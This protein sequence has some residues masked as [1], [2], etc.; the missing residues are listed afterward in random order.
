MKIDRSQITSRGMVPNGIYTVLI[1]EVNN[2]PAASGTEQTKISLE[3]LAPA[4]VPFG[5]TNYEVAGVPCE[6]RTWWSEK[7]VAKSIEMCRDLGVPGVDDAEDSAQLQEAL[8][9][10]EGH[11][12]LAVLEGRERVKRETPLPNQ[13]P[14]EAPEMKDPET[15]ERITD[16]WEITNVTFR[17]GTLRNADGQFPY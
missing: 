14:W 10:L 11:T 13:K 9:K 5:G 16:G 8:K 17:P 2:N 7:A 4:V 12:V 1:K 6:K 15:G 3:I